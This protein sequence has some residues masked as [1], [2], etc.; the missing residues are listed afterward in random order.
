M[1]SRIN[2]QTLLTPGFFNFLTSGSLALTAFE[3]L[4]CRVHVCLRTS[5]LIGQSVSFYSTRLIT[6][7]SHTPRL[8]PASVAKLMIFVFENA[9]ER[10]YLI[11]LITAYR[12]TAQNYK[13]SIFR[14]PL[15]AA[16]PLPSGYYCR[17]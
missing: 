17:L 2:L 8:Q 6:L 14:R 4:P 10:C 11:D 12:D 16:C 7:P 5:I 3:R 13:D 1:C 9:A 15:G